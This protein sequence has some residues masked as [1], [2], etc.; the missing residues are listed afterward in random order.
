[1]APPHPFGS[2]RPPA[3]ELSRT[4]PAGAWGGAFGLR[5]K[6]PPASPLGVPGPGPAG[7]ATAPKGGNTL[8]QTQTYLAPLALA[9][10]T[11]AA[12]WMFPDGGRVGRLARLDWKEGDQTLFFPV[13]GSTPGA[14]QAELWSQMTQIQA[15]V[16][17]LGAC[18]RL[19]QE[20]A[21]PLLLNAG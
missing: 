18:P 16:N 8:G 13:T 6:S 4:C 14:A 11:P 5:G 9:L 20:V 15:E 2:L 3:T 1:M 10:R 12:E 17:R 7:P 21:P 19:A